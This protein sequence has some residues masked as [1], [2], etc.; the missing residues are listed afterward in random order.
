M[1]GGA[2]NWSFLVLACDSPTDSARKLPGGTGGR[3]GGARGDVRGG[4]AR[5]GGGGGGSV[6]GTR[7]EVGR[8][9]LLG[10]VSPPAASARQCQRASESLRTLG[11]AASFSQPSRTDHSSSRSTAPPLR[12]LEAL[13]VGPIPARFLLLPIEAPDMS[14]SISSEMNQ[15]IRAGPRRWR[16]E[17]ARPE[18]EQRDGAGGWGDGMRRGAASWSRGRTLQAATAAFWGRGAGAARAPR[19]WR[20][21]GCR[22]A[23]AAEASAGLFRESWGRG[24]RA[25]VFAR[26][27]LGGLGQGATEQG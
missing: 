13:S 4:A 27:I 9:E 19:S 14:F 22:V 10:A 12:G 15:V 20:C 17:R 5:A 23:L 2:A 26:G 1:A 8:S 21:H 24:S 6:S 18:S 25:G 11:G 3:G 16:R 7:V